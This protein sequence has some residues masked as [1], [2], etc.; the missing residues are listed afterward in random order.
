[1]DQL[2]TNPSKQSINGDRYT[3][4]GGSWNIRDVGEPLLIGR[5]S[6]EV[7]IDEIVWRRADLSQIGPVGTSLLHGD[8]QAFL[9]H[10]TLHDL[11]RDRDVLPAKGRVNPA[12]AVAAV[13]AFEDVGHR[14]P[15]IPVFVSDPQPNPMIKIGASG[16]AEAGPGDLA[17][18]GS[19]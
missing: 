15:H 18:H 16:K 7:A 2:T 14:P 12:V 1:M 19:V 3:L 6:L 8:D 4:P 5:A 9:L 13:I 10:Q 11:L 17:A